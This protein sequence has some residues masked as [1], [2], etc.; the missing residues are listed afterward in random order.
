MSRIL[1]P[2]RKRVLQFAASFPVIVTQKYLTQ[3]SKRDIWNLIPEPPAH[4]STFF[5]VHFPSCLHDDNC[6]KRRLRSWRNYISKST[7]SLISATCND[8]LLLSQR[9]STINRVDSFKSVVSSEKWQHHPL[10][11]I[12]S[13][14]Y[15]SGWSRSNFHSRLPFVFC[16]KS[17][18]V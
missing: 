10:A 5:L 1:G 11:D 13:W 2:F 8:V 16:T 12:H 17:C 14:W 9:A 15:S 4:F 3:F 7:L 6:G 18:E